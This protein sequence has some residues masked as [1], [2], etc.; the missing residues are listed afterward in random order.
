[1]QPYKVV[2]VKTSKHKKQADLFAVLKSNNF[3]VDH[4]LGKKDFDFFYLH[5]IKKKSRI[6]NNIYETIEKLSNR[7]K[8]PIL[9]RE[10]PSLRQISDGSNS[11]GIPFN[12][13]W[14]KLSWNSF[15]MDEG[16]YP[17]DASY[18]RWEDLCKKYNITVHDWKRRGD[19]I[20]VNLQISNDSALNKL[21]YKNIC[22]KDYLINKLI[23][24]KKYSDRPLIIRPHPRE[25]Q[26]KKF[27]EILHSMFNNIIISDQDLYTDL[28]RSW[29]VVTYNSTSCVETNLYGTP[30][31]T[32][33][34]S[35]VAS[36]LS[37]PIKYIE[38]NNYPDRSDWCKKIAFHQWAGH[39]LHD[40]YVWNLLMNFYSDAKKSL[41][42]KL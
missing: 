5:G 36:E 32:L 6:D 10:A 11:K 25:K 17:Y 34:S 14:L 24:I 23:E 8:K 16:I 22:Y 2:A 42:S 21:I 15:F 27:Y 29:C 26:D 7:Y 41:E 18:N 38:E 20:L 3:I 39:E 35:A 19:A 12:S 28:N 40:S 37:Q 31:I 13:K 30:T 33:D 1:M 4:N 9:I